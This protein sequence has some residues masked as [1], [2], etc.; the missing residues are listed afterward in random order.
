MQ[1]LLKEVLKHQVYPAMGCTEPV[2]VALCAAT[3]AKEAKG[4]II[5]ALI[6]A[7]HGTF[8]NGLGVRIPN[9]HGEKGNLLA[10]ALG[11][12]IAKP[13]LGMEILKAAT[14][15][16][17]KEAKELV[18]KKV[19][20]L[21]VKDKKGFYIEANIETDKKE[22]IKC[23]ISQSH[24]NVSL[25][26]RNGKILTKNK[27]HKTQNTFKTKLAACSLKDLI[28]EAQKADKEDLA[29]IKKGALM[30]LA[31]SKQGA[32]LK[33]VG[34]Y[35]DQLVKKG[36]LSGNIV[37]STKILTSRAA[38]ARMDGVPVPVM[39]SGES[40]NQGLVAILAPYHVGKA[41]KVKEETILKSIAL[42]HLLNGYVKAFTGELAP[43][44]GCAIAA[45]V[46]ASA[47]IVFQEKSADIKAITLAINNIIS[48][49]GGMLCDGA[50]SGC[51]LKV[52]S[53]VDSALRAAYMGANHYGITEVE[54]FVGK[55]AEET[56]QNL[57]KISNI[58]MAHVDNT[59]VDIMQ[60]K[61]S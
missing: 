3:A 57:S 52:V 8:K 51:A 19:V 27:L 9:T 49:I 29:Y 43:I 24:T 23:I 10:A 6:F 4:K 48:D 36:I 12:L 45:G 50:K 42:S 17:V 55:T 22:K 61:I 21:R 37:N 7:D 38:D 1:T 18:A 11:V 46:G 32:K 47:A 60:G 59:I 26:Q 39:S 53:S 54:G 16:I 40:G 34:Y 25:L 41:N 30:N 14:P 31:A 28:E 2:S 56:I 5:S 44:C 20:K 58:G 33:K 15:K 13:E 35:L